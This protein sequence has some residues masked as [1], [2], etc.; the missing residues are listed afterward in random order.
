MINNRTFNQNTFFVQY[1]ALILIIITVIVGTFLN[2]KF[3]GRHERKEITYDATIKENVILN[4][5]EK[6]EK[7][8][9]NIPLYSAILREHNVRGE[10]ELYF[11]KV[12]SDEDLNNLEEEINLKF[13]KENINLKA[14][15]IFFKEGNPSFI[16]F[17]IKRT[18]LYDL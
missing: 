15:S 1:T 9:E 10:I 8:M 16:S 13:K 2:P 17:K 6:K 14:L 3:L 18:N 11:N 7:F 12:S 5:K 4:V